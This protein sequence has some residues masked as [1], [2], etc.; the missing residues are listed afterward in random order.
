MKQL[1]VLAILKNI[2]QWEGVSH[3][4]WTILWN[5]KM[6]NWLVVYL[7][8]WKNDG[9]RQLGRL[10]H[11]QY[12]GKGIKFHGSKA[13]T[14]N[15]ESSRNW[16]LKVNWRYQWQN[17]T[18]PHSVTWSLAVLHLRKHGPPSL[19]LVHPRCQDDHTPGVSVNGPC[20]GSHTS[21]RCC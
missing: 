9:V 4:L 17:H 6:M 18:S 2:S 21:P 12:D 14:R 7:P 16:S 5:R 11:S 13:P 8:L 3:I 20:W 15:D 10:F 19:L 1:V